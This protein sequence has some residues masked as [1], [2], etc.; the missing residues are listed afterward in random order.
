[1]STETNMIIKDS[2]IDTDYQ[3]D[4]ES[5]NSTNYTFRTVGDRR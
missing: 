4:Y 3:S 2:G 1:M 5:I